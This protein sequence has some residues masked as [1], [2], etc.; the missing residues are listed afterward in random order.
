MKCLS[1]CPDELEHMKDNANIWYCSLCI[2]KIFPLNN[3]AEDD[4]FLCELNGIDIDE[5]TIESLSDRLF[6]PFQLNDKDYYSPL[7][8]I[9]PDVNFYNN[10]NTH[11]GLNCNYYM[12]NSFYD[13]IKARTNC[14]TSE[15][16]FSL[17]HINIRSLRANLFSLEITRDNLKTHFTAIGISETWLNDQNCYLYNNEGYNLIE[18]H[19]QLK[20]GGGVGISLDNNI[21]YQIRPDIFLNDDIFES[22]FIEIDKDIFQRGKNIIIG[23]IYRPPGTDLP[24]FNDSMSLMLSGL[25]RENKYSYLMG[26]YNINL[27]HYENHQHTSDF[28]DQLHSNSFISLINK[29]T[30]VK[31]NQQHW[32]IIYLQ[33]P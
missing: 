20:K 4:I 18:T 27:L 21:P 17:C 2:S 32:L 22:I 24:T 9:D 30:R 28:I 1:L 26:D 14:L 11:L 25:I 5:H 19:R 3:I 8:Q 12:E 23:V 15:N 29:P 33:V 31:K 13:L 7:S 6:N 10:I 16:V